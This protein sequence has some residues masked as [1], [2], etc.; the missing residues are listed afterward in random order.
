MTNGFILLTRDR[1]N[2]GIYVETTE[3]WMDYMDEN[4]RRMIYCQAV[5][6]V[7]IVQDKV[8]TWLEEYEP[9]LNTSINDQIAELISSLQ[10]IANEHPLE[11]FRNPIKDLI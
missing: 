8:D 11:S 9:M 2:H 3:D 1:D 4:N 10:W 6:N 5:A 7:E